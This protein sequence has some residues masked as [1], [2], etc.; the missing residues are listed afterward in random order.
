VHGGCKGNVRARILMRALKV[1][2]F[3][4]VMTGSWMPPVPHWPSSTILQ[5]ATPFLRKLRYATGRGDATA[6]TLRGFSGTRLAVA[7][8]RKTLVE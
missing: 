3:N 6:S 7:S 2:V 8:T 5:T 4:R 1:T